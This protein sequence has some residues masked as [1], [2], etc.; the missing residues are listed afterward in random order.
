MLT[1]NTQFETELK[2]LVEARITL[3]VANISNSLVVTNIE[4]YRYRAGVIDGLRLVYDEICGEATQ[5]IEERAG[6]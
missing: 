4:D 2:S 3:F 6:V 5:N 1:A